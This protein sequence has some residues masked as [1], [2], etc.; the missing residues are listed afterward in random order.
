M[1]LSMAGRLHKR[2]TDFKLHANLVGDRNLIAECSLC[3][4][5]TAERYQRVL[6][7]ALPL[8]LRPMLQGQAQQLRRHIDELQ[9]M[10]DA[11][12]R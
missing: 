3:L 9:H 1:A 10:Q 6:E 8:E 4:V 2:W 7:S 11:W 12:A 5:L